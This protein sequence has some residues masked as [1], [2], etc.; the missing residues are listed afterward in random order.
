MEQLA[1]PESFFVPVSQIVQEEHEYASKIGARLRHLID[2][3]VGTR[4]CSRDVVPYVE[5]I[6]REFD[7]SEACDRVKGLI[8][9]CSNDEDWSLEDAE[10]L[11]IYDHSISYRVVW[12][13]AW[14]IKM[15]VPKQLVPQVHRC[16]YGGRPKFYDKDGK[17]LFQSV[18]SVN[19]QI[20]TPDQRRQALEDMAGDAT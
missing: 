7:R 8:P 12:D 4:H 16:S 11:G 5:R 6:C 18:Y 13:R 9:L 20:L 2:W 14:A 17:L 1:I 3:L 15:L 19:G 10:I